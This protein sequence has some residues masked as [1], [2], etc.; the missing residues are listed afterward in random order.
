MVRLAIL[1]LLT[2]AGDAVAQLRDSRLPISVDAD[3]SEIDART[4]MLIARGLRLSQGAISIVADE[5]RASTRDEREE[6]WQLSG[7]VAIEVNDNRVDCAAAD[8]TIVD[9]QIVSAAI[10][11]TPATFQVQRPTGE[12]GTYAEAEV[13][14]YDLT[15]GTIEFSGNAR[16][17]EGGNQIES[18]F[19]VYDIERQRIRAQG[20]DDGDEK[21]KITFTPTPENESADAEPVELIA[22]DTNDGADAEAQ[23]TTAPDADDDADGESG[24]PIAPERDDGADQRT[25]PGSTASADGVPVE[26][27]AP[28]SDDGNNPDEN[29]P[30]DDSPSSIDEDAS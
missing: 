22:P 3:F 26:Q 18:S 20:S 28:D 1:L 27:I 19:L 7:N 14:N 11:G 16:I 6:V 12:A 13:L 8:L 9:D 15:A 10:S 5:G 30:P 29:P 17:I 2:L 21:V 24:E 25:A 23:Q 4:S